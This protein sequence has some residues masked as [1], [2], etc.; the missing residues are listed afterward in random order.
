MQDVITVKEAADMLGLSRV[1][2]F[3]MIKNGTI[4]AQMVGKTYIIPSSVIE[5]ILIK[6]PVR[7]A[8]EDFGEA[9]KRLGKE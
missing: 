4:E 1:Q 2:I 7:K 5:D 6:K 9:L 3:R 8:V